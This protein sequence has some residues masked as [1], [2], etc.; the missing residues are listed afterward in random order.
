M[1]LKYI[2]ERDSLIQVQTIRGIEFYGAAD[3]AYNDNGTPGY[4][5]DDYLVVVSDF[6]PRLFKIGRDGRLIKEVILTGYRPLFSGFLR[7][8]CGKRYNGAWG[9]TNTSELHIL[10][11]DATESVYSRG[12]RSTYMHISGDVF[13]SPNH[14]EI[15]TLQLD[16]CYDDIAVNDFNDVY[17]DNMVGGILHISNEKIIG[18]LHTDD[19]KTRFK[20]YTL[21]IIGDQLFSSYYAF[22]LGISRY[23]FVTTIDTFYRYG[24]DSVIPGLSPSAIVYKIS[25]WSSVHYEV[26]DSATEHVILHTNRVESPGYHFRLFD[27]ID[28]SGTLPDGTYKI[29]II[30]YSLYGDRGIDPPDTAILFFHVVQSET[31]QVIT[32]GYTGATF[33]HNKNYYTITR[34]IDTQTTT[35]VLLSDVIFLNGM[36]EIND[37]LNLEYSGAPQLQFPP[38][39][40]AND[41]VLLVSLPYDTI[42]VLKNPFEYYAITENY[43]SGGRFPA[44]SPSGKSF[45][46]YNHHEKCIIEKNIENGMVLRNIPVLKPV[47]YIAPHPYN[48]ATFIYSTGD[49]LHLYSEGRDSI[50][51]QAGTDEYIE[52]ARF[53]PNGNEIV[54]LIRDNGGRRV[55]YYNLLTHRRETLEQS[56]F[57]RGVNVTNDGRFITYSQG[58]YVMGYPFGKI[59]RK[60]A[61]A[62]KNTPRG[63]QI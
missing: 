19:G 23:A 25:D 55:E 53:F 34:V 21:A 56:S 12:Q 15:D 8:E 7:V 50:V 51:L 2:P 42:F 40:S 30:T 32:K 60:T 22:S 4:I 17:V 29:R 43:I 38:V 61:P 33:F 14:I 59:R 31:H 48:T 46:Y 11:K 37:Y 6:Q 47:N 28:S 54:L 3:I 63:R 16:L 39:L 5:N 35:G 49:A 24:P 20:S 13:E 27:G 57:L 26:V 58:E 9:Y 45:Y 52:E 1:V 36:S 41:S 44:P 10:V 62:H 18:P